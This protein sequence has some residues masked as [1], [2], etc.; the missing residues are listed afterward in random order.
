M[1]M[2]PRFWYVK[3]RPGQSPAMVSPV[4]SDQLLKLLANDHQTSTACAD[5]PDGKIGW[6]DR[7]PAWE[8][9]INSD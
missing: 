4:L 6:E 7:D 5:F 1:V 9:V 2:F 8:R 3:T